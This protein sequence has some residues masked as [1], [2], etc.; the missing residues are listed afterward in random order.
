LADRTS[1]FG[2][3]QTVLYKAKR[4]VVPVPIDLPDDQ[5][6]ELVTLHKGEFWDYEEEYR[7]VRYPNRRYPQLRFDG[8]HAR[9]MPKLVTGITVGARMKTPEVDAVCE[10][11]CEH[12]PKLPVWRAKEL[13]SYR[14]DFERLN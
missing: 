3:A 1:I 14:F 9:Y 6:A 4:P 2:S 5:V 12:S 13:K 10:L 11:A 8:Q 7:L